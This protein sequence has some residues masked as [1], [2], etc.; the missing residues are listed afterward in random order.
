MAAYT[1]NENQYNT[2]TNSF[3]QILNFCDYS[4]KIHSAINTRRDTHNTRKLFPK[5]KPIKKSKVFK[6]ANVVHMHIQTFC[7]F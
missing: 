7:F 3:C 1:R 2:V 6:Y 5:H 4:Y